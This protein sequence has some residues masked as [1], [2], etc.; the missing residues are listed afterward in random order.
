M[1][2]ERQESNSSENDHLQGWL[3]S[4]K[5]ALLNALKAYGYD[6]TEH[7]ALSIPGKSEDDIKK[8]ITYFRKKST[9]HPIYTAT[10]K[11]ERK[12][13]N[14]V[15]RVPLSA[16][17]KVLTDSINFKELQTETAAA[18]RILAEFEDFPHV[19]CG[20]PEYNLDFK[21]IYHTLA[22]A[23]EGKELPK[24]KV[25]ATIFEKCL[26]ETAL[27]SKAFIRKSAFKNVINNLRLT[28][29]YNSLTPR[30]PLPPELAAVRHI[31]LQRAYNP[32]N[33]CEDVLKQSMFLKKPV[34]DEFIV[35]H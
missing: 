14:A 15:S 11:Q 34:E 30:H 6:S 29:S 23:L 1:E 9:R 7:L 2:Q 28:E 19:P 21:K 4:D 33:V 27:T 32:F 24:N 17:G 18:L 26:L 31:A 12:K 22:N 3:K 13:V 8:A 5:L 35:P 10:K 25:I 16:W 20:A